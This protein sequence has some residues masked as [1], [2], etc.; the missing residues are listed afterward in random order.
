MLAVSG[1]MFKILCQVNHDDLATL[2]LAI[3]PRA[4]KRR[5]VVHNTLS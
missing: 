1:L 5:L 3:Y 4:N 2:E